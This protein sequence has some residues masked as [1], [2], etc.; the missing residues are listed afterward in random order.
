MGASLGKARSGRRARRGARG[1]RLA[2]I[3]V[4]PFVDVMLVLLIVFM[5]TAP[6]LTVSVP[7]QLPRTEAKQ[8]TSDNEPISITIAKDGAVYLQEVSIKRDTLVDQM[9]ALSHENFERRVFIRGD[10]KADYGSVLEVMALLSSAGFRNLDLVSD[11]IT[12]PERQTPG[13]EK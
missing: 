7:V 5:V 11:P 6:L 12:A 4:T 13:A 9:R 10:T 8:T 2:E 1:S 3:N